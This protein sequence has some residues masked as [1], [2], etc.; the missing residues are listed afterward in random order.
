[1]C[2]HKDLLTV[3]VPHGAITSGSMDHGTM[4]GVHCAIHSPSKEAAFHHGIS[5]SVPNSLPSLVRVESVGNQPGLADSGRSPG[6]LKFDIRGSTNF[7]PHSLPEHHDGLTNG[8]HLNSPGTM[9]ANINPSPPEI[10]DNRQLH[11]V[12]S[13]G[14]SVELN[15]AGK[16]HGSLGAF[17]FN[18]F[19]FVFPNCITILTFLG[20]VK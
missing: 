1:M 3:P 18:D 20:K 8:V 10:F 14:Q 2:S 12:S 6:Q 7:H 11:R 4:L 5:S 16:R 19:V 9:T 15:E 17:S 13:N